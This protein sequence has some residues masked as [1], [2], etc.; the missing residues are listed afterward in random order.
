[1]D[2][3][4]NETALVLEDSK[5]VLGNTFL[6]R[7]P[8]D[9]EMTVEPYT[10]SGRIDWDAQ[11]GD[12][13]E[14]TYMLARHGFIV[15]LAKSEFITKES[16]FG[17]KALALIDA[18]IDDAP[19]IKKREN[20]SWRSL[21]AAI[22]ITNW[23]DALEILGKARTISDEFIIRFKVAV[24]EHAEY[25]K[26]K[27]S[28]FLRLSNWGAIGN[29]GLFKASAY[30]E[31]QE[32]I[33]LA[34]ERLCGTMKVQVLPDGYQ[35]EQSPMYQAE[36]LLH[37]LDII[38]T[39]RKHGIQIPETIAGAAK[40]MCH[41]FLGMLKPDGHQFIQGDSDDTCLLD[42]LRKGSF[43]FSDPILKHASGGT[44]DFDYSIVASEN[45][46]AR[47]V[48]MAPSPIPF[49]SVENIASGNYFL[50]NSWG[51]SGSLIH[52]KCG[53]HGGGHG[54]G[55][56]LHVDV[57]L[58]GVD[59]LIDSGR[60]TY[61]DGQERRMLKLAS[62][63]NTIRIDDEEPFVPKDSWQYRKTAKCLQMPMV[64][65]GD[66]ALAQGSHL[67]Y[68]DKGVLPIRRTLLI[69]DVA[70]ILDCIEGVGTH[71]LERFFHFNTA[72]PLR[73]ESSTIIYG[74]FSL[75]HNAENCTIERR[76]VSFHYN[77]LCE[78]DA[79]ILRNTISS[80]QLAY[81]ILA[82]G[83]LSIKELEVYPVG[84]DESL[85]GTFAIGLRISRGGKEDITLLHILSNDINGVF[86]L[87]CG[88]IKESYGSLVVKQGDRQ[89]TFLV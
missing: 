86:L 41:A 16:R 78:T 85:P 47:F 31:D 19:C 89:E 26:G 37:M 53:S 20:T 7:N 55:D 59:V 43:I 60:Y 68:M 25:L 8:W 69:D 87:T 10:F 54:H 18:F 51:P 84:S 50:R 62:H 63:H 29:A 56:T 82:K 81:A 40:S 34:L 74:D 64:V 21:D 70:I 13:P 32:G 57:T 5:R 35:W 80:K 77:E 38:V 73:D 1:M 4:K 14:W 2:D 58:N 42:I 39:G 88:D 79:L 67:A 65:K 72:E 22:R 17:D 46:K 52:F 61:V 49:T 12:D 30:T 66:W 6:F 75:C 11:P 83:D 33:D 28:T 27:D 44:L 24:K 48:A 71:Q 76:K 23:L 15:N 3:Y 36:V 45:D 9:M